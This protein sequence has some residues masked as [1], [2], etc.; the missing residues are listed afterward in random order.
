MLRKQSLH[1]IFNDEWKTMFPFNE[2]F[3]RAESGTIFMRWLKAVDGKIGWTTFVKMGF[4]RWLWKQTV[5]FH[6]GICVCPLLSFCE[7]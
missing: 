3:H 1:N 5:A 7:K 4:E 2:A 6:L